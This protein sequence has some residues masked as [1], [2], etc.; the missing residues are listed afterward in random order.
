MSWRTACASGELGDFG[1]VDDGFAVDDQ[2]V[3]ALVLNEDEEVLRLARD[4]VARPACEAWWGP[5][6]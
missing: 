4:V 6:S 1:V 2:A 3:L 5:D